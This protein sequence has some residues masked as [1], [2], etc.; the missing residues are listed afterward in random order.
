MISGLSRQGQLPCLLDWMPLKFDDR[1][2]GEYFG[3]LESFSQ[4]YPSVSCLFH[5]MFLGT[6]VSLIDYTGPSWT[7]AYSIN[8]K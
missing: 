8:A 2:F 5:S 7:C 6:L 1:A 3:L 4:H